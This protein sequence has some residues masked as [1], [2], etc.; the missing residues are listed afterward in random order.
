[1]NALSSPRRGQAGSRSIF[2]V[3]HLDPLLLTLLLC[4]CSISLIV[5]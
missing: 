3:L 5:I 4:V 2:D 1:M